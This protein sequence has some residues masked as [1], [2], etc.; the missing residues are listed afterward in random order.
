MGLDNATQYAQYDGALGGALGSSQY[1][2]KKCFGV[3]IPVQDAMQ[4]S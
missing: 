4:D 1:T 2:S 3:D